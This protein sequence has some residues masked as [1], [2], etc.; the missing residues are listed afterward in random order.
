MVHLCTA[1]YVVLWSFG[2]WV[3]VIHIFCDKE[4]NYFQ[5]LELV[6][7]FLWT[8]LFFFKQSWGLATVKH[9]TGGRPI[10]LSKGSKVLSLV[11]WVLIWLRLIFLVGICRE[12][13]H[14]SFL[15]DG[16]KV[17]AWENWCEGDY[18]VPVLLQSMH[19]MLVFFERDSMSV[20]VIQVRL[21]IA[22]DHMQNG[23]FRFI[24]IDF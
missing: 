23:Y 12:Y 15:Q 4:R 18:L 3:L 22:C 17:F 9:T 20:K 5:V 24:L 13:F 10:K 19:R 8:H 1:Y 16:H 21:A 6:F 7:V 2:F 14:E 11:F